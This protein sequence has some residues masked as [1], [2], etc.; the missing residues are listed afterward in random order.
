MADDQLFQRFGKEFKA[1]TVLF[2]DGETGREMY[3]IQALPGSHHVVGSHPPLGGASA[4]ATIW[5]VASSICIN[6]V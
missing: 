2:R 1:G 4:Q 5:P 3:V 6:T